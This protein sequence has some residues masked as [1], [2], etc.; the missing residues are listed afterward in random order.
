M[1]TIQPTLPKL[2]L[3]FM[4]AILATMQA[5][6]QNTTNESKESK[7]S[8]GA[9]VVDYLGYVIIDVEYTISGTDIIERGLV[10]S[11]SVNPPTVGGANCINI[12]ISSSDAGTFTERIDNLTEETGYYVRAYVKDSRLKY[13]SNVLEVTTGVQASE[14]PNA[15]TTFTADPDVN[16]VTFDGDEVLDAIIYVIHGVEGST[17]PQPLGDAPDGTSALSYYNSMYLT[18]INGSITNYEFSSDIA[19]DTEYTFVVYPGNDGPF[20]PKSNIK[21]DGAPSVTFRT[22]KAA[23]TTQ[24]SG[25]SIT[26]VTSTSFTI[27]WINGNGDG[28]AVF[29]NTSATFTDPE[30]KVDPT[31]NTTL[32]TSQSCVYN[33]TGTSVTVT[34]RDELENYYIRVY[35]YNNTG[36]P[37]YNYGVSTANETEVEGTAQWNGSGSDWTSGTNWYTGTAPTSSQKVI[38]PDISGLTAPQIST[39]ET[40]GELIIEQGG[41]L[42]VT[43]TG[44]L[45]VGGDLTIEGNSGG[46]GSLVVETSGGLTVSGTSTFNRYIPT[47]NWHLISNPTSNSDITQLTGYYANTWDEAAASWENLTGSSTLTVMNGYSVKN[48]SGSQTLSFSGS[49]NNGSQSITVTNADPADGT[50]T[51]GWNMVGNPYPSAIDWDA[52]NGWTRTGINT[53]A[54]FYNGSGYDTYDWDQNV[55]LS[56]YIPAFQGFFIYVETSSTTLGATNDVRVNNSQSFYKE[57]QNDTTPQVELQI[58]N[59]INSNRSYIS[60]FEGATDNYDPIIDGP[61]LFGSAENLSQI[62]S[63]SKDNKKLAV[64]T[65]APST[66]EEEEFRHNVVLGYKT[67]IATTLTISMEKCLAINDSINILLVDNYYY[68]TINL[69]TSAYEFESEDGTIDDRFSIAFEKTATPNTISTIKDPAFY[70]FTN[71]GELHVNLNTPLKN[72]QIIV[73]D[74][75]GRLVI[76]KSL[77]SK[78]KYILEL[79]QKTNIFVV[80]VL[81]NKTFLYRLGCSL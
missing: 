68:D 51:Y 79:P 50:E 48:S 78:T 40:I 66:I 12:P 31:A 64:N 27:N 52:A 15:V 42:T 3:I 30:R 57:S 25:I 35:E 23:P 7:A 5:F 2:S 20:D 28:R 80:G 22:L 16:Y 67:N 38:I 62:Y 65:Y 14:P 29:T 19:P 34:G 61:K 56:P 75:Y 58:D 63:L 21:S 69:R 60:F 46:S 71:N 53:L 18:Q 45:S 41:E 33:G 6:A 76:S 49:F 73:Y 8:I 10:Y 1:K 47:S 70:A 37:I 11:T 81:T 54:Q 32:S 17:A 9:A 72:G 13:S 43:S 74:I 39:T 36:T 55:G 24:A 26:E 77:T 59:G 4:I 44:S